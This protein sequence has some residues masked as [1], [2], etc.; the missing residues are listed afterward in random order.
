MQSMYFNSIF[1]AFI[2]VLVD[3]KMNLCQEAL[4]VNYYF[5][6][7]YSFWESILYHKPLYR[8]TQAY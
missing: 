3:N 1:V 5:K 7:I 6:K 4:D 2:T 8:D